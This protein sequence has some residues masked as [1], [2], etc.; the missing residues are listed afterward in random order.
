VSYSDTDDSLK[1]GKTIDGKW[2]ILL[3]ESPPNQGTGSRIVIGI[4]I[5]WTDLDGNTSE[6]TKNLFLN[7]LGIDTHTPTQ[8]STS[9]S[10]SSN[11]A[12]SIDAKSQ[13]VGSLVHVHGSGFIEDS[14]V[15]LKFDNIKIPNTI[16]PDEFGSFDAFFQI[17]PCKAG[18]HIISASDGSNTVVVTF[19]VT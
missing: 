4:T 3:K 17:P 19:V 6:I 14:I 1:P 16:I 15:T 2:T 9:T 13:I 10:K 18:N 11:T 12:L 8:N 5:T 7:V